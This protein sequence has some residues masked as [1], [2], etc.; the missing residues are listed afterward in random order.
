LSFKFFG[1]LSERSEAG[2]ST[3]STT[4]RRFPCIVNNF[5]NSAREL[6]QQRRGFKTSGGTIP[7]RPL[8]AV[9]FGGTELKNLD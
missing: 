1:H 8:P 3:E 9:L 2:K 6:V 4:S 7:G 5:S